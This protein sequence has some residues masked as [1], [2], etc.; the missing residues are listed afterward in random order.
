VR[1]VS[2]LALMLAIASV[3]VAGPS[4]ASRRDDIP[5]L[6]RVPAGHRL[7]LRALGKGVQIYD[8][9]N[10]A[11]KFREPAAAILRGDRTVALHYAGPKWQSIKD[12]SKVVG[13]VAQSVPAEHPELDIPR[14][15]LT[16]TGTGP[17][18]FADVDYIQRLK[19]RGGVAPTG[20]CGGGSSVGVPY[21]A[22][23]TFWALA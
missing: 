17:G 5:E 20:A 6:L 18:V 3:T 8:C 7:V 19:T 21:S 12:G 9:V 14:L 11:W 13:V 23:Y 16:G 2:L 22:V 1:R 15:L 4:L 10:G